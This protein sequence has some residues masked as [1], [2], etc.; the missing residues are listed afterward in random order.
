MRRLLPIG[1]FLLSAAA[2]AADSTIPDVVDMV[3]TAI[4]QHTPDKSLAKSIHRLTLSEKLDMRTV[5]ELESEGAG[6]ES[7]AELEWLLDASAG[8]PVS[9]AKPPFTS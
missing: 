1:A 8:R 9:T 6:P 5:E 2:Q 4:R 7:V 3:R